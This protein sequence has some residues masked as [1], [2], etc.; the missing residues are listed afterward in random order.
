MV[1]QTMD[2]KREQIRWFGKEHIREFLDIVLTAPDET[3]NALYDRCV[4]EYKRLVARREA[5]GVLSM[6]DQPYSAFIETLLANTTITKEQL[7]DWAEA[8]K[9]EEET[10]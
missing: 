10:P 9:S 2:E 5:G 6:L 8:Q 3:I 4:G 7:R 1:A